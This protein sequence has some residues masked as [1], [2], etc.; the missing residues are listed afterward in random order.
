MNKND[1]V[2]DEQRHYEAQQQDRP[3][4]PD[5]VRGIPA[6]GDPGDGLHR[7]LNKEAR[8]QG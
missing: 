6:H 4:A 5:A 7:S 8:S 3:P 2:L 1:R